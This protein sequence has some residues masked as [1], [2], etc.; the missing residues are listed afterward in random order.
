MRV[1]PLTRLVGHVAVPGDKSI[2]HRS[3]L[4]GALCDGETRVTGFGR[5]ADTEATI[6]AVR[7]LG[8]TVYEHDHD[9][10]RIF[11]KGLRG[12]TA[13]GR[14]IDCRNAG[15][16][17]RLLSGI[18]AG[19]EGQQ[20][21]LT[22][23]ASLSARPMKR[24][25][26]PLGRMGAAVETDDGHLPMGIEGRPLR[27]ITYELPVASA[28]VKSAILLA[29]L[30]ATGETTVVEP[31]PTRDHT[32]LMLE[33]A[34][35]SVTRRGQSVT[36]HAA[37]RLE[38]GEIEVPG[39]FSSAAPFVVAAT[40]VPGSELHIH[41]VNLNPR[42]IGLLT[43]LERM[44][45]RVTVYNRRRIAGEP[46][47]DLEVRSAE[48]VA[49][50]VLGPEV[51]LAI[52]ELPLFA[53]AASCAHGNSRLRGAEELRAKESD[54]VEATVD[55]LRAIGQHVFATADGFRIRGVPTRPR[56]GRIQSRGDHRIAMLGAVAALGSQEGV[57]IGD[58]D[59][60]AVSFPGFFE[61]LDS[62]R[63]EA[64]A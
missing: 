60:V 17:V 20:F 18:L 1:E 33:A 15:T 30:Y 62:L 28:Q 51:P 7:S 46:A 41:G 4:I 54:R 6:E 5:S 59:C 11:G 29:G 35:A 36:V 32:E 39:D 24:V 2:S 48:L 26:E 16:L 42:R 56:G 47:G 64:A 44:G 25:T 57:E 58:A 21:E 63:R 61:L 13:P 53:L 40:L 31:A 10:L 14:S 43:I 50:T 38:L 3:V 52:D 8:V 45:G 55:A 49:T 23:D 27:S 34:G 12:L 9:T 22:G 37:E 19:Q